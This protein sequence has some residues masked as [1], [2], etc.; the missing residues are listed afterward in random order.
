MLL[1]IVILSAGCLWSFKFS[2]DVFVPWITNI[3]AATLLLCVHR[4]SLGD[5]T[6]M[7]PEPCQ[8][9]L[10]ILRGVDYYCLPRDIFIVSPPISGILC[11]QRLCAKN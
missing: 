6:S 4:C 3:V 1:N 5:P 10:V 2:M 7:A 9:N 11:L 8:P